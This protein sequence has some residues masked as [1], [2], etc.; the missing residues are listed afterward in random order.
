MLEK[1]KQVGNASGNVV[2]KAVVLMG[3]LNGDGKV[4]E[5]TGGKTK[6]AKTLCI[7]CAKLSKRTAYFEKCFGYA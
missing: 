1:L 5:E 3:D 4:D 2:T 7:M 6:G